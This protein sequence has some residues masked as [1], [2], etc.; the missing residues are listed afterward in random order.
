[1]LVTSMTMMTI[2]TIEKGEVYHFVPN[3]IAEYTGIIRK[4]NDLEFS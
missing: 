2:I 4:V 1:M 3:F